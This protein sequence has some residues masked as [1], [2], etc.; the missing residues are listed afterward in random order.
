MTDVPADGL[1]ELLR[2]K[3]PNVVRLEDVWV[4]RSLVLVPGFTLYIRL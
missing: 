2:V 3:G 4:H 1:V